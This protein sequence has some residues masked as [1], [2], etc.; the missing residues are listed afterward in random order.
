MNLRNLADS[1]ARATTLYVAIGIGLFYLIVSV[2]WILFSDYFAAMLA[3]G[4]EE[5]VNIQQ[6]KGLGFVAVMTLLITWLVY[7][8]HHHSTV[9]QRALIFMRTDP[10][11]GLAN[12]AVA[13][14]FLETRLQQAKNHQWTCGVLLFDIRGLNRINRSAGRHGGDMLL[15]ETSVRIN[16]LLRRADLAARLESD[17]FLIVFGSLTSNDE[18]LT[19]GKR[20]QAAFDQPISIEEIEIHIELR[21]GAAV[22]PKDGKTVFE[23]LDAAER[24]LYR[25]KQTNRSLDLA[26][27]EDLDGNAGYLEREA[28]LRRAIREHQFTIVLQPQIDLNSFE[29]IGA[30]VLA[31]W[32]CPGRGEVPPGEFIP[33]AESLGLVQE[34]TEQI[35]LLAGECVMGWQDKGLQPL[36]LCV[37]LSGLDLKNDRILELVSTSLE[38]SHFPH[39]LLT[40]EITESWLMEDHNLALGLIHKLRAMGP[41]I[42]IDDF[43]TGYSALSQLIDFPFDYIKFDRSFISAADQLP[44]KAQVLMAI[45]RLASTLGA[46]TVAEGVETM[47][48]LLLLHEIGMDEAQGFLFAR[49]LTRE[50]FESQYLTCSQPPFHELKARIDEKH[51]ANGNSRVMRL[52]AR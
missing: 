11:T 25:C 5:L 12:R 50:Q 52:G 13:E 32:H 39:H 2:A 40:L 38:Q 48:E 3:P 1:R 18:I 49:P 23:L 35:L 26:S 30:E 46:Q 27:H 22:A 45:Q 10:V 31:R 17:R 51:R 47:D 43:G 21:G 42:A 16:S 6:Y 9:L 28:E 4:R 37:N 36:R 24:A 8:L 41:R 7:K 15:K 33:L 20:I 34:I 29:V 14:E 19:I 44:R